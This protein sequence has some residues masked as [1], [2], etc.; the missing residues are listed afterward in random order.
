MKEKLKSALFYLSLPFIIIFH[1]TKKF[2]KELFYYFLIYLFIAF[3]VAT[4][5]D[6][7]PVDDWAGGFIVATIIAVLYIACKIGRSM[8]TQEI[9]GIMERREE[10]K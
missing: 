7:P 3:L 9:K 6:D 10:T 1:L 8:G 2:G 4:S 5:P